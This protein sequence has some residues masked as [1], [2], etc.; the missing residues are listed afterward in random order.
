MIF[1]D[2]SGPTKAGVPCS[3]DLIAKRYAMESTRVGEAWVI[4]LLSGR[5]SVGQSTHDP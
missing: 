2:S 5:M 4:A 3:V 1:V